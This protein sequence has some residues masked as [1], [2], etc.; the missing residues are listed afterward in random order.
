[1]NTDNDV[2]PG[3]DWVSG[4]IERQDCIT[5]SR[6]WQS[7]FV[8]LPCNLETG[9][10]TQTQ[11]TLMV[12]RNRTIRE[13]LK[14]HPRK[15]SSPARNN[16][17]N[18]SPISMQLC[19]LPVNGRSDFADCRVSTESLRLRAFYTQTQ[20]YDLWST[21]TLALKHTAHLTPDYWEKEPSWC[22][23]RLYMT[24]GGALRKTMADKATCQSRK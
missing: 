19:T 6:Y 18:P 15:Q 9:H 10:S 14:C 16:I 8:R 3:Q 1:M 5:R 4:E 24:V 13:S 22:E 11:P 12:Q 20:I 17:A 23:A 7:V 21:S 2:Q